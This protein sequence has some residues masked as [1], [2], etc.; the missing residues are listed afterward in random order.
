MPDTSLPPPVDLGPET[1]KAIIDGLKKVIDAFHEAGRLNKDIGYKDVIHEPKILQA[2]IQD[3][4]ADPKPAARIVI[5]KDAKPVT[6][7]DVPLVCGVTLSQVQQLLV[8]TCARFQLEQATRAEEE[9]TTA[10]RTVTKFMFFKKTEQV[11]VKTGGGYD[12]RK[13]RELSRYMAYDW[14]LSLLPA[15]ALIST[16]MLMELESDIL[17]LHRAE[18]I[19]FVAGLDPTIIRKVKQTIG[20]DFTDVLASRPTA[21]AGIAH[22]NKDMYALYRQI[23]ADKAYDFFARDKSFF[24][25]CASLD[26]PL[27]RIYGDVLCY[28]AASNLEEIQRLNIDKTDVLLSGMKFAFGERLEEVL[29]HPGLAKDILRKLVDSLIHLN[30]EKEQLAMSA[31]LTCKAIAPQVFQWLTK[32]PPVS[33]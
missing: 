30:Q 11:E 18:D 7:E 17:A 28:I 12:E 32:Q 16:P 20:A 13:V 14:Q 29:S 8:K 33:A 6:A 26:K 24:M 19:E 2:F 15:Y 21:I 31:Q 10:T 9:I 27:V 5:G 22:W 23:L 1:K 4:R 25:V 3:F